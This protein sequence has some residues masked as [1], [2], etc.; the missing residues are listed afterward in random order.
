MS[1]GRHMLP[2]PD[3]N[4][5]KKPTQ[6][7]KNDNRARQ[8]VKVQEGSTEEKCGPGPVLTRVQAKKSDKIHPLRVK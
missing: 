1:G 2:D 5:K 3:S 6:I 7:K 4:S 8:D